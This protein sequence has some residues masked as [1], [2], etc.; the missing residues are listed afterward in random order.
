LERRGVSRKEY[1]QVTQMLVTSYG[2]QLD[3]T[4]AIEQ[5]TRE[6]ERRFAAGFEFPDRQTWIFE[7]YLHRQPTESAD[8][9]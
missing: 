7:N 8:E 3:P 4:A 9:L 6:A 2:E 1:Q 5:A